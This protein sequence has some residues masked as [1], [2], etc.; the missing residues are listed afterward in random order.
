VFR[1]LDIPM[2]IFAATDKDAFRKPRVGMWKEMLKDYDLGVPNGV[3]LASSFF[4]GDA[5]GRKAIKG[6]AKDFS[7]SDR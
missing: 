7:C 4:V 3:D 6:R 5:G 1:Q 2:S